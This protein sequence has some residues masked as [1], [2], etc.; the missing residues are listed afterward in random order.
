[1]KAYLTEVHRL[2]EKQK[3]Y[4]WMAR[5]Q[6]QEGLVVLRFTIGKDGDIA[7]QKI[8]RSSGH[9]A[10]DGAAHETLRKVGRFPPLPSSLGRSQLT[11]AV[12]LTF[13]L[14]GS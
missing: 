6:R 14:A 13:R 12:P 9:E 7:G 10:L 3:D 11:I 4:P 8:A 1:L 5:R 2:L